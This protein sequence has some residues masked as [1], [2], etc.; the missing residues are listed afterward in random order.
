MRILFTGLWAILLFIFTCSFSFQDLIQHQ[1]L[2]FSFNASPDWS[3]LTDQDVQWYRRDWVLRKAGHLLGFFLL[4]L[5]ASGG[6]RSTYAFGLCVLY[7]AATE[8]LQLYFFRGG[9][10]YDMA[11]DTLG[12]LMA[13]LWCRFLVRVK[14]TTTNFTRHKKNT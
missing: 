9:R 14:L 3:E 12:V 11:I 2:D 13:Y 6:G 8:I 4:A 1:S 10:I 5:L 7:A